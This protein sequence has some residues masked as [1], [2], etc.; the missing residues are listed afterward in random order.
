MSNN[1]QI[2]LSE[3]DAH[4]LRILVANP[5]KGVDGASI[6]WLR[7]E[8]DRARVVPDDQVPGDVVS[9]HSTVEVE[10]LTDGE[11]DTYTVVLP[12]EANPAQGRISMLAPLGMGMIGYRAGSE[13]EWPVPAGMARYRIHRIVTKDAAPAVPSLR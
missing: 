3:S 2:V 8:L 10:D 4:H 13:F 11:I 7:A 12:A 6:D 9:L 1:P 5:P